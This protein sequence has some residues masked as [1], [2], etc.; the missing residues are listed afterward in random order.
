MRRIA[1]LVLGGVSC[2]GLLLAL[3]S[4]GR[5]GTVAPEAPAEGEPPTKHAPIARGKTADEPFR[6]PDDAGGVVLARV[7]PP[8]NSKKPL[9]GRTAG[10]R[11]TPPSRRLMAPDAPPPPTTFG[12]KRLAI[13]PKREPLRPRLVHEE[14]LDESPALTLPYRV[15]LPAGDR[16]RTPTTDLRQ[17][18]PLPTLAE[19]V[20]DRASM[21][22]PTAEV[23]TAA[24][25]SASM[26]LRTRPAPF[27]RL[28]LPDPYEFRQPLTVA[29][30]ADNP[31]P[32]IATPRKPQ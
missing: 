12:S 2:A 3:S 22:D 5:R 32:P 29:V 31:S 28:M 20:V 24:V 4:C 27:L 7:L 17:P 30:P 14:T 23:S 16:V 6:F 11:R 10:P 1:L 26:P 18:L 13:L 25:L 21:E 15:A 19:P 8:A 9:P